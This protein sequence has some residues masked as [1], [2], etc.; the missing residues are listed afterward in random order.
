MKTLLLLLKLMPMAQLSILASQQPLAKASA[1][2]S[3]G[4]WM[5][6]GLGQMIGDWA[7]VVARWVRLC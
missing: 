4:Q 7:Q 3:R 6:V 5:M 1:S 2:H